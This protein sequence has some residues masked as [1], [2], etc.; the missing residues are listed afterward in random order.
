MKR[1][2][3]VGIWERLPKYDDLGSMTKK[4]IRIFKR[5]NENFSGEFN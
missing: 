1:G 2:F 4:V 5:R 3:V